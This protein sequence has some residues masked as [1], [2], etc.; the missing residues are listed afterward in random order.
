MVLILRER[1]REEVLTGDLG[2]SIET[3]WALVRGKHRANHQPTDIFS[4]FYPDSAH[5]RLYIHPFLV[6]FFL[7]LVLKKSETLI[8]IIIVKTEVIFLVCYSGICFI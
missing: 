5:K 4:G 7:W 6:F 2:A 3:S 8:K 1:E